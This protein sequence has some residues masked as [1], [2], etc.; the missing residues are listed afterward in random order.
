MPP[1]ARSAALARILDDRDVTVL[2]HPVVELA[3]GDVVAFKASTHGPEGSPLHL[4]AD[5]FGAAAAEGRTGELDWV[6]RA[7]AFQAFLDADL[8]PSM[9]LLVTM[10]PEAL[11]VPCPADLVSTVSVAESRLR[12][13]VGINE[14]ELA[15]DPGG[16][17]AAADR[18]VNVGW[19][20][21][22]EEVGASRAPL[23]LLPVVG[24]DLIS[25]D[26]RLLAQRS[27]DDAAAITLAVLQQ[28]E[29]TGGALLV[30]GLE[31]EADVEWARVLGAAYGRGSHLGRAAPVPDRVPPPR[32]VLPML[33]RAD[34]DAPF[35][36]PFDVVADVP[37]RQCSEA[38]LGRLMQAVY[39]AVLTPGSAPVILAGGGRGD[40][41]DAA[42]AD[43]F[44][45]PATAPL[46]L[47]LFGTGMPPEPLPGLRGVRVRRDD[48]LAAERFLIVLGEVG[49]CAVLARS[50]R[51]HPRSEVETVLTQDPELVH[52]LARQLIRRIPG[53]GGS[54]DA[55]PGPAAPAGGHDTV[56]AVTAP[57]DDAEPDRVGW[58]ARLHRRV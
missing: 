37:S 47:V 55:L 40:Q 2:F 9:S 20:I 26:L 27:A 6:C 58:R 29:L 1:S 45:A 24:A 54:H 49:A 39:R 35:A 23:A 17:L 38:N 22:I 42:S 19:G 53:A 48:P 36:S 33:L 28:V 41:P 51:A 8:P 4:P 34:V 31:S 46:L 13:F 15:L 44:P 43:G 12:V 7:R 56:D 50:D 52:A 25:L 14:R 10:E 32:T 11:A 16:L 57:A 18:A 3:T 21:A 30:E 5:L